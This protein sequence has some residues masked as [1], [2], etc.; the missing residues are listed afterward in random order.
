MNVIHKKLSP[1]KLETH[2]TVC[3]Q[4]NSSPNIDTNRLM[5]LKTLGCE[6]LAVVYFHSFP[7]HKRS[8][9]LLCEGLYIPIP[10]SI[11]RTYGNCLLLL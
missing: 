11:Y 3:K 2:L 1:L 8:F 9:Q 7:T 10:M 6:I 5:S 4:T